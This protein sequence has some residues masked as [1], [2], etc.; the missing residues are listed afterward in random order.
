VTTVAREILF[1]KTGK[2]QQNKVEEAKL[3]QNMHKLA[4]NDNCVTHFDEKQNACWM[5]CEEPW[6]AQGQGNSLS[7]FDDA[8]LAKY[9]NEMELEAEALFLISLLCEVQSRKTWCPFV[10]SSE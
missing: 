6:S 7:I 4:G 10:A 3:H 2:V 9:Q 5:R 1:P 8:Q